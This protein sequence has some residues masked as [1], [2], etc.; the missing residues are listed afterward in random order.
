MQNA[1][2]FFRLETYPQFLTLLLLGG[3]ESPVITAIG[4]TIYMLGRIAYAKGY[5]T[6]GE[7]TK[8]TNVN[9]V[10]QL[11]I[12]FMFSYRS[13]KADAGIFWLHRTFSNDGYNSKISIEASS[14]NLS[15]FS[16]NFSF[17]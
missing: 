14:S 15:Y 8:T 17:K 13:K 11:L 12:A 3:L 4:G 16:L 1:S 6:G 9:Y 5:Y 10:I 7:I 2:N